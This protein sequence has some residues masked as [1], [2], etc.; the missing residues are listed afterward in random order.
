MIPRQSPEFAMQCAL[1]NW[2]A[3][4]STA[5]PAL[6]LLRGS[7]N[8]VCLTKAQAG[9]AKAAGSIKGEHDV[10]LPVARGGYIGLSVELKHGRNKPTK[11]QLE[12]GEMLT[13]EGWFVAYCW[14]WTEAADLIQKYLQGK[15]VKA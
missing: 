12:Y 10:T 6:K 1:F 8:G 5:H 9:K 11:E 14:E 3:L 13:A 15:I 7:M 2:A 4:Q